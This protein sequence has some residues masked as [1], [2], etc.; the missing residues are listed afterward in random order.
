MKSFTCIIFWG[1][2]LI[3]NAC[4]DEN[5]T[6]NGVITDLYNGVP[7]NVQAI[8]TGFENSPGFGKPSTRTF[9]ADEH[10][11]TKFADGDSIGVFAVKGGAI[12][13]GIDNIPLIYNASGRNWNSVE[14]GKTLYWYDGISYVAYYPYRKNI[15]ID[16]SEDMD[17]IIASLVG[18]EK[19][20]PAQDQSS[21][22][23][24]VSSDL[25]IA[26]GV[27]DTNLSSIILSFPFHHQFTLL[28]LHPQAYIGCFAPV[29]AGFVYHKESRILRTDSAAINVDLNGITPY[30]IDSLKYCAIVLPQENAQISGKYRTTNGR[31]GTDTQI[32]YSGSSI[33]F[34][35][36][37][38]YMLKVISPVPGIGSTERKLYPGDFI[39]QNEEEQR[40]EVY[41]GDGELENDGKIY[42]YGNA[43]GMVIT[44]DPNKMTDEKCNEEG[45]KHAYVMGLKNLGIGRW[46]RMGRLETGI[47]SMTKDDE[48]LEKNMNGYSETEQMLSNYAEDVLDSCRS[49]KLINDYRVTAAVPEGLKLKRS[50]W[51]IPSIGQWF[52][53]LVNI[54]GK[55]PRAFQNNTGN[56]LNDTEWGRETLDKLTEQLFKVASPLPEF[57]GDR[58]LG[59][60]CS[61]Q[62]DKNRNWMLLWHIDDP[63]VPTWSRICLQGYSKAASWNV[64]PFFAF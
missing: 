53:M 31:D 32:N 62:Y 4:T 55:S 37:K 23:K 38:C 52:D 10:L 2:L 21:P 14:N 27:L 18:N 35:S 30:R 8:I 25:M 47:T 45:W 28:V 16:A 46:G 54:C 41:P 50:P 5:E 40:I 48:D 15:T 56:G 61:S 1:I 12:V 64:R 24:Y 11:K 36:G 59:F 60:S 19:L 6:N 34:A 63:G 42:D 20:Q 9:V 57:T 7:L 17:K 58:R 26:I 39:F 13:D 33:A 3:C 49:F 43:I 51:F 44:C 22:E 29:D